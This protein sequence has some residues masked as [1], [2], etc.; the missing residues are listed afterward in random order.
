MGRIC[1]ICTMA[2]NTKSVGLQCK[3]AC[4]QWFHASCV[5]LNASIL[6]SLK[7]SGSR[8]PCAACNTENMDSSI[9]VDES[10]IEEKLNLGKEFKELAAA[11][12]TELI[13]LLDAKHA[14]LLESVRFCSDKISDFEAKL[15]SMEGKMKEIKRECENESKREIAILHDKIN[16]MEQ[17]SR[18]CNVEIQNVPEKT[19]ENV[20]SIVNKIGECVNCT[21]T[22]VDV[23]VA[24]R[25]KMFANPNPK[26][27][28]PVRD[29]RNIVVRFA[30]RQVRDKFLTACRQ[31]Q[32]AEKISSQIL[33]KDDAPCFIYRRRFDKTA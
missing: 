16:Q 12:K 13:Q 5:G 11:F 27:G 24:H 15:V 22:D 21:L 33:Y 17:H 4:E 31:V 26:Q 1:V 2:I 25:V 29:K 3:G 23:D 20:R 9:I 14:E 19:N 32:F 30:T 8:W 7:A 18:L 10:I 28:A 6:A